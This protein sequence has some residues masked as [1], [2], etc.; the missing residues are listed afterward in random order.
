MVLYKTHAQENQDIEDLTDETNNT[1]EVSGFSVVFEE[2][3]DSLSVA[4][5]SLGVEEEKII[6]RRDSLLFLSF[7][8]PE[9]IILKN[10]V[11]D[12]L[13]KPVDSLAEN[14]NPRFI[15]MKD[16]GLDHDSRFISNSLIIQLLDS[17]SLQRTQYNLRLRKAREIAQKP[18]TEM[19]EITIEDYK[20]YFSDGTETHLDTTLT[21]NKDYHFNYLRKDYFELLPFAN[22]GETFNK[23]GYDFQDQKLI[24]DIGARA[25]HY[26]YIEEDEVGYYEVPSP[27]TEIF[28]KTV[29]EQGQLLD[30][31]I[32]VNTS[33]RL[34]IT[35]AHKAF[36]S[37]GNYINTLGGGTNLRFTS[38]Y[39]SKNYRYRQ[40]SHFT[41]Q[42]LENQANGGLDS[43][44]VYYFE[45]A[46]DELEYDGFLDRSRLTNNADTNNTLIG[47]RYY[48]D[49]QY[50]I[51]LGGNDKM[52]NYEKPKAITVGHKFNFEGKHFIFDNSS[53]N[54]FFGNVLRNAFFGIRN[55]LDTMDNEFYA[56]LR[57]KNLGELKAGL[58]LIHWD[59][60]ISLPENTKNPDEPYDYGPTPTEIQANQIALSA[61]WKKT[62]LKF[63]FK[64]EGYFSAFKAYASQFISGAISRDFKNGISTKV[65][66]SLRSQT[67][68]FNF[69]LNRSN[70]T[71]YN[72]YN[73]DFKNQLIN[74]LNFT[75]AYPKWGTIE[76]KYEVLNNYTYFRNLLPDSRL[77]PEEFSDDIKKE[78]ELVVTPEQYKG[79]VGYLKLRFS[80]Q[81]DFWKFTLSNTAQYQQVSHDGD[82]DFK[83]L[84][85]PEWNLRTSFLFS[86]QLFNKALYLQTGITAQYFTEF[87]ADRYSA[88]LGEFV[89][90]NHT[91]IGKFPRL[92]F[93]V[94][95]KIQQTRLFLKY[96][97]FNSDIT[98]YNYY[99]APFTPYRD[100]S[101]RFGLV[102][103]F[104]Q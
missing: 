16:I 32:T 72:W 81:L 28:F 92:D 79:T 36:R 34:N 45:K 40:R 41:A 52:K 65:K 56:I 15:Y 24:P 8:L 73:P 62:F 97:H 55:S 30:A 25:K 76:G 5:D 100:S 88:H 19:E 96:E 26:G 4:I 1:L 69:I 42:R 23:L 37:L 103:N 47:R 50:D 11:L 2:A 84:N 85:V 78:E 61:Y 86:S 74:T 83:P 48:L 29:F 31:L 22:V 93:F 51:K 35:L 53:R 104:F 13:I 18:I 101:I 66:L 17:F 7:R 60:M 54:S 38:Q 59:Y 90:Q 44:S 99:S 39:T 63:D 102:W 14:L 80:Q 6:S 3:S 12:T 87:Y 64:G 67:P 95:A 46:V 89:S 33:P 94:N 68:N 10:I 82:I 43:L 98:G 75:F 49:H 27:L 21:I 91:K 77:G 20:I 57:E 58:R 71:E 70:F 9:P